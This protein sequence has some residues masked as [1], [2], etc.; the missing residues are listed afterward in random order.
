MKSV[1]LATRPFLLSK[2]IALLI[3]VFSSR[4]FPSTSPMDLRGFVGTAAAAAISLPAAVAGCCKAPLRDLAGSLRA[5]AALG[6]DMLP[7]L[8][9]PLWPDALQP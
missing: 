1:I 9:K 4:R 2:V 5:K 6:C 7:R 3:L 8:C